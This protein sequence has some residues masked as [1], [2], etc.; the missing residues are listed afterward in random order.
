MQLY[1]IDEKDIIETIKAYIADKV[2]TLGKHEI[3]NKNMAEKYKYPLKIIFS[4]E[5][6]KIVIITAYPLRKGRRL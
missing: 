5:N 1:K 2:L 6:N 3:V 4:K